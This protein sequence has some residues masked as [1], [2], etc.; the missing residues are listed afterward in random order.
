MASRVPETFFQCQ[1]LGF[2]CIF[3]TVR[4]ALSS[5]FRCLRYLTSVHHLLGEPKLGLLPSVRWRSPSFWMLRLS[6]QLSRRQAGRM[7]SR[8]SKAGWSRR[9]CPAA[10]LL[11]PGAAALPW[12]LRARSGAGRASCWAGSL[13]WEEEKRVTR[14]NSCSPWARAGWPGAL[15]AA[16]PSL[17]RG[18]RGRQLVTSAS[19]AA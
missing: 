11:R 5:A 16:S 4:A 15:R 8:C 2:S 12:G 10:S 14:D 13:G 19:F 18:E 3:G 1:T 7:R 6:R 17:Q 9:R